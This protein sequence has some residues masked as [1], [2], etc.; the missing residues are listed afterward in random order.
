[1]GL[2]LQNTIMLVSKNIDNLFFY[3]I[4]E[5]SSELTNHVVKF[6]VFTVF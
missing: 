3:Q 6:L 5:G 2:Y 4:N 1:M